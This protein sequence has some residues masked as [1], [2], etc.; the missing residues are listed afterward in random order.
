LTLLR[1][2]QTPL[3]HT[4]F[5]RL[6]FGLL[7]SRFGDQLALIALLWFILELTDS[8]VA[9][10]GIIL[11]FSLPGI[12]TSPWIGQL[13]DR[14]Q[15]RSVMG[16]DNVARAV[17]IGLLPVLFWLGLLN[18]WLVYLLATLAGAIAPA[19]NVGVRVLL[20]QIV[21]DAEL[22]ASNMLLSASEQFAF[23]AGPALAGILVAWIGGPPVLLLDAITFL[24]MAALLFSL[25]DVP[26]SEQTTATKSSSSKW[27][28]F[29]LLLDRKEIRIITLLSFI[30][31]TAYGPLEPAMPIYAKEVLAVGVEGY[32][33]LW[34]SFGIGALLGLLITPRVA[35]YG[36][37]GITFALIA[38]LWGLLLSP[39]I[40]LTSMPVAMVFMS[41][42]GCAWAPY[43][44]VE[45]SMLQRL[46]PSA[47]RGQVFG[48]RAALMTGSVPIGVLVGGVLLEYMPAPA[49]IGVSALAC[50]GTGLWG[51]WSP[52]LRN[53]QRVGLREV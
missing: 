9:L 29:R 40:I 37:P 6:W 25:P 50:I 24:A 45:M 30:F 22:E 42:A 14:F 38:L 8:G 49:V 34:S 44:T 2:Q 13:L 52:T 36:R 53:I 46:V 47:L 20:P 19:T 35:T 4:P 28:G 33:L 18:L 41:L 27:D 11:C 3:A 12:V 7:L 31:F 23:F 51:L 21:P 39:L 26:R 16:L 32:G 48:A 10:G 5:R 15:P 43:T 17:I 1:L